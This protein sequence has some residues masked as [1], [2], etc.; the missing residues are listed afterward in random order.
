MV[1]T[2][3]NTADAVD[4]SSGRAGDFRV[5]ME[6]WVYRKVANLT[7]GPHPL[8]CLHLYLFAQQVL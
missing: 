7:N 3:P 5:F 2:M 4:H 8:G 1:Q 6:P